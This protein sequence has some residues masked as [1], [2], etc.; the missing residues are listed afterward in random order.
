[1]AQR[2][3]DCAWDNARAPPHP[4]DKRGRSRC[5]G[6]GTHMRERLVPLSCPIPTDCR[7]RVILDQADAVQACE[8]SPK[9]NIKAT[10]RR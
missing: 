8:P 10:L 9:A 4:P 3:C 1:M 5:L 7:F 6:W 2:R